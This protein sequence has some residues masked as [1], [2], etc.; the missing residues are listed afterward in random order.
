MQIIMKQAL[1][2][3][4]RYR[5]QW[6]SIGWNFYRKCSPFLF[7]RGKR[8]FSVH[9]LNNPFNNGKPEPHSPCFCRKI[10]LEYS[11]CP[12]RGNPLP[13]VRNFGDKVLLFPG[14]PDTYFPVLFIPDGLYGVVQ[15]VG[16]NPGEL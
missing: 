5:W 16:E 3:L 13:V 11:P 10:G 6:F 1:G 8:N 4:F 9:A 12:F 14:K 7:F 2:A 15:Q